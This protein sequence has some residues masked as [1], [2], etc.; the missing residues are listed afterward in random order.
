VLASQ[1]E[2]LKNAAVHFDPLCLVIF[3]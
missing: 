1:P 3:F 2:K